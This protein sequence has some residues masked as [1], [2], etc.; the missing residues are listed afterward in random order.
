MDP[1]AEVIELTAMETLNT[2]PEKGKDVGIHIPQIK[3]ADLLKTGYRISQR[4]S[5]I[6]HDTT[7]TTPKVAGLVSRSSLDDFASADPIRLNYSLYRKTPADGGELRVPLDCIRTARA[8][9]EYRGELEAALRHLQ[10]APAL[11]LDHPDLV[12]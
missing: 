9:D 12:P 2:L 3:P 11:P 6:I 7:A 8:V 5:A 10:A 4:A 1:T